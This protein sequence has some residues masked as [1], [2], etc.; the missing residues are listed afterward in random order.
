MTADPPVE[1]AVPADAAAIAAM[2]RDL[3]ETGLPWNWREGRVLRAIRQ[4]DTNVAVVREDARIVG[5]GIMEYRDEHAYL[6]LLAIDPAHRRRGAAR[7]LLRWLEASARVAGVERI[8]LEAR[9][10][11]A[12]ARVFYNEQGFHE[13]GITRD[14]YSDGIDGLVLE[15]WLRPRQSE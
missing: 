10:D 15:K 5:F 4:P 2:S 13:V 11:N 12:P 1:L 7:S 14:R 6:S 8:R 9:R 3:I